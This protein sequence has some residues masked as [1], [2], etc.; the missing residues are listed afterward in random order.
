MYDPTF[1]PTSLERC[2][3]KSDFKRDPTLKIPSVRA[4]KI[5][6]AVLLGKSGFKTLT[7]SINKLAGKNIYQLTDLSSELLLRKAAD[8]LR[9]ISST[10]QSNRL[11]IVRRLKLLCE[12][13]VSFCIAKF[14]I[15]QFYESI[16]QTHLKGL[17][18]LHLATAP[19]TRSVLSSFLDQCAVQG[20]NGL[21][22]G[23]AISAAMSELYMKKFDEQ[24]RT[25][26]GVHLY[27]RYVDDIVIVS[28]PINELP[29]LRHQ[30]LSRLPVGLRLNA[31]K[32]KLLNFSKNS[33][34]TSKINHEFDY[35]GF[36]FAVFQIEKKNSVRKVVLDIAKLKVKK[37]KTRIIRSILQYLKDG[38]LYDL[39]DRFRLITCNYRFYDHRKS[40]IRLAGNHN[41][42][43][44]IDLPSAA[45]K[46]MDDFLRK[47]LLSNKGKISGRLTQSLTRAQRLEL[48]RLSFQMGFQK[49][50]HYKFSP[51]RLK[52]L[53]EC[54]KYA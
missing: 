34:N 12:E 13:D 24:Q 50:I 35:L 9:T 18:K 30:V 32:T 46:E 37:R 28:Q 40:R 54:W 47:I 51:T 10:K 26:F 33:E 22:R 31:A 20:I 15:R 3:R 36:S 2:L 19:A 27:A 49:K 14:D 53:I 42:Y 5:Q 39:R 11:E 43:G 45:L 44:L 8:N 29:K 7:L 25:E 16:D 52:H 4:Q 41:T 17:L 1:G 48:L 23:L 38:K 21:P 6:A